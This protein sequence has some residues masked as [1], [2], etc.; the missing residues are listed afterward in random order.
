MQIN[1][2]DGCLKYRTGNYVVYNIDYLLDHQNM[3]LELLRK[4]RESRKT[5]KPIKWELVLEEVKAICEGG[6][7]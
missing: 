6:A 3:E 1:I 2:T 5:A 7:K 4:A